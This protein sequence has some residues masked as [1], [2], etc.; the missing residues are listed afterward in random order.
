[1]FG[2]TMLTI[3]HCWFGQCLVFLGKQTVIRGI[4]GMTLV[5]RNKM[6]YIR[7]QGTQ[8][9]FWKFANNGPLLFLMRFSHGQVSLNKCTAPL[10]APAI[11]NIPEAGCVLPRIKS[12]LKLDQLYNF[13]SAM[14][15]GEAVQHLTQPPC[16]RNSGFV[17]K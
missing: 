12:L 10:S 1:M 5:R 3:S 11:C 16:R 17:K 14:C 9:A 8:R 7:R 13:I 2:T 6:G 4:R 15:G